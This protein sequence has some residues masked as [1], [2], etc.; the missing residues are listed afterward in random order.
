MDGH[1]FDALARSLGGARS[2]RALLRIVAGGTAGVF[3]PLLGVGRASAHRSGDATVTVQGG[4]VSSTSSVTASANASASA[5]ANGGSGETVVINV[6]GVSGGDGGAG[7][8]GGSAHV[9][10][11]TCTPNGAAP[12]T[13]PCGTFPG[14]VP[15]SASCCSQTCSNA[16]N[17]CCGFGACRHNNQC[18]SGVCSGGT[19]AQP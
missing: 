11:R 1:R 8:A 18:C 7:C 12:T 5:S 13:G 17:V 3:V 16:A 4:D 15:A 19:C 9:G 14:G 6:G 10:G 2:R